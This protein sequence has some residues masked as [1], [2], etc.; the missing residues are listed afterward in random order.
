MSDEYFKW[1]IPNKKIVVWC[2]LGQ[3]EEL[4][5]L[6]RIWQEKVPEVEQDGTDHHSVAKRMYKEKMSEKYSYL[7]RRTVPD[8]NDTLQKIRGW[9]TTQK[10]LCVPST[11]KPLSQRMKDKIR[12][13]KLAQERCA[14]MKEQWSFLQ[15]TNLAEHEQ[16]E[17]VEENVT[18]A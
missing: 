14:P 17:A 4:Q 5:R 12:Q 15:W 10:L 3:D 8:L 1:Y 18:N 6:Y 9:S 7:M 13:S 2:I 16:E 11:P